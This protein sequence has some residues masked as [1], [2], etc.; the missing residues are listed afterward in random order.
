MTDY[1]FNILFLA[2]GY[3]TRLAR[4]IQ[5]HLPSSQYVHL[6]DTPKALLPVTNVP[7][8]D[9]WIHK[10]QS[11]SSSIPYATLHAQNRPPPSNVYIVCNDHFYPQFHQWALDRGLPLAHIINDGTVS[12]ETRLGAVKDIA[13]AVEKLQ[14]GSKPLVV[15]A[16]DTLPLA[17]FN[18]DDFVQA[19]MRGLPAS[20]VM[21]YPV[22][23]ESET[24]KT[25]ILEVVKPECVD[26]GSSHSLRV[27]GFIEKPH[28]SE[29]KSRLAC[30]CLYFLS[31]PALA[32]LPTF[33]DDAAKVF[34][35][36][37]VKA[38]TKGTLLDRID[39]SGKFIGWL[40]HQHPTFAFR[41]SG[42]LDIGDLESFIETEEYVRQHKVL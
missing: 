10:L 14:L 15:I 19:G 6:L 18:F 34:Q 27:T 28:P 16:G 11:H 26:Q 4:D 3:G 20:M 38:I 35:S 7:V 5:N 25:G 9:H 40:I 23:H 1:P 37:T 24:L 32:L 31:Q 17:D 33:F 41:I 42:R 30:P 29:T 13:L 8:L 2:A 39:A 36:D 12:N 22:A 21:C